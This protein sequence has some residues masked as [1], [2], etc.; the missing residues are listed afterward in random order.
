MIEIICENCKNALECMW[1]SSFKNVKKYVEYGLTT[2]DPL[3][4]KL[5]EDITDYCGTFK[6]KSYQDKKLKLI[7]NFSFKKCRGE[8]KDICVRCEERGHG[9]IYDVWQLYEIEGYPGRYC[10]ICLEQLRWTY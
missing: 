7:R 5:M 10:P 6:C 4:H 8:G 2:S 1:Y 3:G 9:R